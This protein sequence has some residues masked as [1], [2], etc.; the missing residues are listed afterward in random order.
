MPADPATVVFLSL[1][2]PRAPHAVADTQII[3]RTLR[4]HDIGFMAANVSK[5][6]A[7]FVSHRALWQRVDISTSIN[8]ERQIGTDRSSF[9]DESANGA[10][11]SVI[12][13]GFDDITG[14]DP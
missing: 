12:E 2:R 7:I 6:D 5:A 9:D 14:A 3:N 10:N 11:R 4:S 1:F 13:S 8:P